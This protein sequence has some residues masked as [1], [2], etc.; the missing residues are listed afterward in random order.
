MNK[1]EALYAKLKKHNIKA[2]SSVAD[3]MKACNIPKG[4]FE[5]NILDKSWP[6]DQHRYDNF[7]LEDNNINI[8]MTEECP[9]CKAK[10]GTHICP[11]CLESPY[12][13]QPQETRYRFG[14]HKPNM[15][16]HECDKD[17]TYE[18]NNILKQLKNYEDAPFDEI[19]DKY[20]NDD[21]FHSS[22]MLADLPEGVTIADVKKELRTIDKY[23]P[24]R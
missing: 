5:F 11:S 6:I 17:N 20:I 2:S 1:V 24:I 18:I 14:Q 13:S 7:Y 4:S 8:P 21:L 16:R 3:I 10:K 9:L 19:K 22:N 23:I 15:N 12:N